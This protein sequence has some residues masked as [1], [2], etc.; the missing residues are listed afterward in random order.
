MTEVFS[1]EQN[2][3]MQRIAE[4]EREI[5][6]L[7]PGSIAQKKIRNKEYYYHRYGN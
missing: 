1:M 4:L 3:I 7:P 2:D 6:E 5:S